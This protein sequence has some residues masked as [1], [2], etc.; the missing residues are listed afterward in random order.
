MTHNPM[1]DL[2][3]G[4]LTREEVGAMLDVIEAWDTEYPWE[5]FDH[6]MANEGEFQCYACGTVTNIEIDK[7]QPEWWEKRPEAEVGHSDTCPWMRTREWER[8]T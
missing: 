5:H 8:G 4:S 7:T 2:P 1:R 3:D 6:E